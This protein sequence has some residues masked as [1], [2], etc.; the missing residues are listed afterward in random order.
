MIETISNFFAS[1]NVT[2]I[3]LAL[4]LPVIVMLYLANEDLK[5]R[6]S[7]AQAAKGGAVE[8]VIGERKLCNNEK[9]LDIEQANREKLELRVTNLQNTNRRYAQLLEEQRRINRETRKVIKDL[10]ILD[11]QL[12]EEQRKLIKELFGE[13]NEKIDNIKHT[14]DRL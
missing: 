3:L 14:I 12:N 4:F 11:V 8:K 1:K 6:L 5:E 9:L 10:N 7:I 2:F 13:N